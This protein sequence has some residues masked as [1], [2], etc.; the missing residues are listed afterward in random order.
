MP[1]YYK[2]ETFR[3]LLGTTAVPSLEQSGLGMELTT[4]FHLLPRL[5]MSGTLP[6]FLLYAFILCTGINYVLP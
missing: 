4:N 5:G 3:S 6:L 2:I 1:Q